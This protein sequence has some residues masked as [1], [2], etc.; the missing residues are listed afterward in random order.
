MF[1]QINLTVANLAAVGNLFGHANEFSVRIHSIVSINLRIYS[2]SQQMR[3]KKISLI[4]QDFNASLKWSIIMF[5]SSKLRVFIAEHSCNDCKAEKHLTVT[6]M[7]RNHMKW[8]IL[9]QQNK[10][11]EQNR[12]WE[13]K[14]VDA[15]E[16]ENPFYIKGSEKTNFWGSQCEM[17]RCLM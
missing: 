2:L 7:F 9:I 13:M 12:V 14:M 6:D 1:I 16:F 17:F 4:W 8:N 11:E 3:K 10:F 5:S 15:P